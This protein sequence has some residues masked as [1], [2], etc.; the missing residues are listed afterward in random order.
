L[1]KDMLSAQINLPLIEI[2]YIPAAE[3]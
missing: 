1:P 2:I 3:R